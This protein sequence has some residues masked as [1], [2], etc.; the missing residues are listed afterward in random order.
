[1]MLPWRLT[2]VAP[3]RAAVRRILGEGRFAHAAAEIAAWAR[4]HNGA[5]QAAHLVDALPPARGI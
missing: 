2:R 4:K 3:L 5:G 1:L